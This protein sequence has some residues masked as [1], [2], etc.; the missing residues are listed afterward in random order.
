M[1]NCITITKSIIM[2]H[3]LCADNEGAMKQVSNCTAKIIILRGANEVSTG[4]GA[5]WLLPF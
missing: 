4:H 3:R 2:L 5:C 1:S